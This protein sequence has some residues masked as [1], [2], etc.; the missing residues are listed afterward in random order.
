MP[1]KAKQLATAFQHKFG[2][3]FSHPLVFSHSFPFQKIKITHFQCRTKIDKPRY[4]PS[5]FTSKRD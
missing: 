1:K 4:T 5:R 2:C 3:L